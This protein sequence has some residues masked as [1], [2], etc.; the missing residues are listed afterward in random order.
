MS[1]RFEY[2]AGIIQDQFYIRIES[3]TGYKKDRRIARAR[4]AFY[5]LLVMDGMRVNEIAEKMHR[6]RGT[7]TIG[8]KSHKKWMYSDS[9]YLRTFHLCVQCLDGTICPHCGNPLKK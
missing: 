6:G 8:I 1:E 5:A 3:L 4:S 7:V 9:S 2:V